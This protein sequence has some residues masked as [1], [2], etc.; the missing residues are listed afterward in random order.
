MTSANNEEEVGGIAIGRLVACALLLLFI[1]QL[2]FEPAPEG[3]CFRNGATSSSIQ[4]TSPKT[5]KR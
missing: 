5:P 1:A 2:P 4:L 3:M